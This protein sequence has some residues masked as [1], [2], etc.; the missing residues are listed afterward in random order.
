[1]VYAGINHPLRTEPQY[2]SR[3]DGTHFLD[4][5]CPIGRLGIRL[6]KQVV[7]D[8]M[9]LV[10]LGVMEKI[11]QGIIDGKYS[12]DVKLN[13]FYINMLTKRLKQIKQYCPTDFARQPV[14]IKKHGGLKATEQ[15]LILLYTGP[16]IFK[17]L[18]SEKVYEHF[19][20]LHTA[21]RVLVDPLS[22]H[23]NIYDAQESLKIF[24]KNAPGVYGDEFMSYNV[25]G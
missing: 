18:V 4:G 2:R 12:N 16:A 20:L 10:L 5:P 19:L 21:I 14:D 11:L 7:F 3:A 13:N 6:T 23:E 8:Y 1:M 17:G 22:N 15:R 9:H 25:H 24:V